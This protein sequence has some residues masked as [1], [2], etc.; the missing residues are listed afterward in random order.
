MLK[1]TESLKEWVMHVNLLESIVPL[2]KSFTCL[3][4]SK[5]FFNNAFYLTKFLVIKTETLE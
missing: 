2:G 4:G 5:Y 3:P 1:L